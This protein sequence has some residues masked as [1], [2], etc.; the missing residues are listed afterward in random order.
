MEALKSSH[1][2]STRD[3]IQVCQYERMTKRVEGRLPKQGTVE[4]ESRG[5]DG[6]ELVDSLARGRIQRLMEHS[7]TP[8]RIRRRL[9]YRSR[10]VDRRGWGCRLGFWSS[11]GGGG[12]LSFWG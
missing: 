5:G 9:R 11:R 7:L 4:S 1:L 10:D 6:R 2:R 8:I 3:S 12:R